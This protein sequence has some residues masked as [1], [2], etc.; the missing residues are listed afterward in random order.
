MKIL[1][2]IQGTG[3]GHLA[4][5]EEVIPVLKKYGKLDLFVS[6]SQTDICLTHV[7]KYKS[8]GLSFYF[9]KNGGINYLKT[10]QEA[11]TKALIRE[12]RE[13][14]ADRYDLIINDFEPISAWSARRHRTPCVA[15][16]HQSALLSAKVPKP[17]YYDPVGDWVLHHYAPVEQYVGF[18]FARFDKHIYTPVIRHAIRESTPVKGE[19]YTV[20][21]PAYADDKLVPFLA[22]I[23][24]VRWHIFS[25]HTRK[26]YHI[27]ALSVYP[28]DK[29][30]FAQSLISSAGVICGAG[31]ETPA[32]A[33]FLGKK[34]LVVPMKKQ[35]EQHYN[36]AA[37]RELGVPV[38]K[39][40]KQK[41]LDKFKE[42]IESQEKI[43]IDYPDNTEAAVAEAIERSGCPA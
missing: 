37:L 10:F 17:D 30:A 11:N 29:E 15:L 16:S 22:Q 18:H 36:A 20:Y 38:I 39:N 42:W 27:G 13:F 28:I 31:F 8:K 21:L 19:H 3:N 33:L 34:L 23:P 43:E 12:I 24:H 1:Y 41:Q 2:A 9:G 5:A 40:I 7:V 6:G 25:K 32:E 26:P 14:P 4:R 35:Y